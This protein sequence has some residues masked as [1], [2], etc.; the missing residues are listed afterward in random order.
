MGAHQQIMKSGNPSLCTFMIMD[1]FTCANTEEIERT[2]LDESPR[3]AEAANEE[4]DMH[5][6]DGLSRP[7][8]E[9]PASGNIVPQETASADRIKNCRRGSSST[10]ASTGSLSRTNYRDIEKCPVC[11][12]DVPLD[13]QWFTATT[14]RENGILRGRKLYCRE[15]CARSDRQGDEVVRPIRFLF[16]YCAV[17]LPEDNIWMQVAVCNECHNYTCCKCVKGI[18]GSKEWE[19]PLC[20]CKLC[21]VVNLMPLRGHV[22]DS[23]SLLY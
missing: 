10:S 22:T 9:V 20:R 14:N 15:Q 11:G 1:Y 13:Q 21:E 8:S 5:V 7:P 6:P 16:K 18:V 19:C 4:N 12:N 17:C 2:E 3:G 23:G